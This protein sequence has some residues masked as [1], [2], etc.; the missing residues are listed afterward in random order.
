[1]KSLVSSD[2]PNESIHKSPLMYDSRPP[3]GS[4]RQ[5]IPY[6]YGY[7]PFAS[8]PPRPACMLLSLRCFPAPHRNVPS[9]GSSKNLKIHP[10]INQLS[11]VTP[12]E[13]R[14]SAA[15]T[16]VLKG[17]GVAIS[18][19]GKGR[20][21]DNVFVERLWR[22]VKYEEVYLHAYENGGRSSRGTG[23]LLPILQCR[24]APSG[25]WAP[26]TRCGVC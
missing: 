18:M 22:S 21:V 16:D 3:C 24:A 8:F 5:Y 11:L 26:H 13:L 10:S 12:R 4:S 9:I 14:T 2:I 6:P 17:A 7:R 20:W 15:F 19:D 1:M 23:P 25:P